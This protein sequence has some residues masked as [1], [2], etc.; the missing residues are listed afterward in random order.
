M[1]ERGWGRPFDEPIEVG[2]R[3]LVVVTLRGL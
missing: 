2:G 3:K 1:V